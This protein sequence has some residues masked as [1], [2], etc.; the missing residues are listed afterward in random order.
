MG[1]IGTWKIAAKYPDIWAALAP[2][3]GMGQPATVEQFRSI[4]EIV[5]HGDADATVSVEGSRAMVAK[6]KELGVEVTYLEVPGGSH[7]G[8]VAP[9]LA[10]A[11][12]F[13]DKHARK[14]RTTSQQGR[15]PH[16]ARRD[17]TKAPDCP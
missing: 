1:A 14:A 2:F 13:F 7:G 16:A 9:N 8:V 15:P 5:V 17:L 3:S 10:A 12:E 6:M 4:P 11:I